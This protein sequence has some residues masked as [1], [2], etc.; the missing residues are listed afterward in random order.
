LTGIAFFIE[1]FINEH[2]AA[3]PSPLVDLELLR[4]IK[5]EFGYNRKYEIKL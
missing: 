2:P 3:T 4:K 1:L 5:D